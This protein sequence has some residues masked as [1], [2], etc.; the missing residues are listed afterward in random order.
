MPKLF[1]SLPMRGLDEVEIYTTQSDICN[2]VCNFM[3]ED[4]E[5]IDSYVDD[6]PNEYD[7]L[8]VGAWYLGQSI[9]AMSEADL[10]VFHPAWKDARGCIVEHMICA[11]YDIPYVEL[12]H[13]DMIDLSNAEVVYDYTH[14]LDEQPVEVVEKIDIL[15]DDDESD[16]MD[17]NEE[18][19]E[20][21]LDDEDDIDILEPGEYDA[22]AEFFA[23]MKRKGDDA[24]ADKGFATSYD[25]RELGL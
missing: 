8:H 13:E 23:N 19:A 4:F 20:P 6:T 9:L 5:L 16:T 15:H 25:M 14:D 1:V 21:D 10:V 12:H 2:F 3:E 11:L 24:I 22:D 7:I 17:G 18:L